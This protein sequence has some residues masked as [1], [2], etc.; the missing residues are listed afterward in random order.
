MTSG[1][2]GCGTRVTRD[3][4]AF[5]GTQGVTGPVRSRG[6]AAS[7]R[8]RDVAQASVNRARKYWGVPDTVVNC[9]PTQTCVAF[10]W[11]SHGP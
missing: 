6:V 5:R 3:A 10:A 9:P 11:M 4:D 8:P 2:V 1:C 7:H